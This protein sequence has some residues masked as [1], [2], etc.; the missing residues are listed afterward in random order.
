MDSANEKLKTKQLSDMYNGVATSSKSILD[1]EQAIA[2]LRARREKL[3][4]KNQSA[5]II[6]QNKTLRIMEGQLLADLKT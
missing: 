2:E 1:F 6:K 3:A 4:S 5:S